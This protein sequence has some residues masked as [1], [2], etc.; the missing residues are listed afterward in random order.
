[1]P[2]VGL[3]DRLASRLARHAGFRAFRFFTRPIGPKGTR[4]TPDGVQLRLLT[5]K[6]V[7]ALCP[8]AELNLREHSVAA[9]YARGD[10][11]IGA[12][13]GELAGYCWLAFAPLPHLDG[14][15]VDFDR[16]MVWAYKS[17]VLPPHR[18]RGIAPALYRFGDDLCRERARHWSLL[19]VETHN[20]PS[21]RASLRA[22]YV[23]SGYA[24]YRLSNAR[25]W[26]WSSPG[27]R[28][29]GVNFFLP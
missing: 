15:N 29:S 23:P 7:M 9:A 18:G 17:L 22:G 8:R 3:H 11:C 2:I 28:R 20:R 24:A 4:A 21:I 12:F 14:V 10:V 6:D 26:T 19:C 1:M 5:E 25:L 13:N 27:A 16:R